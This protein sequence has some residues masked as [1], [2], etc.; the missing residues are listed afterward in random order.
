[1]EDRY[2]LEVEDGDLIA[3]DNESQKHYFINEHII[4]LLNQQSKRIKELE[5]RA[6]TLKRSKAHFKKVAETV[7][8]LLIKLNKFIGNPQTRDLNYY[9]V[10]EDTKNYI[11]ELKQSQKQLAINELEK[12][13]EGMIWNDKPVKIELENIDTTP[14]D[15]AKMFKQ[16]E[17]KSLDNESNPYPFCGSTEFGK[18]AINK[19]DNATE[20]Q[21]LDDLND[22]TEDLSWQ[23][24]LDD[25]DKLIS[26]AQDIENIAKRL[27]EL[28]ET[29]ETK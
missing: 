14:T 23:Y 16:C 18:V 28:K 6:N 21:C 29:N 1:M 25:L 24:Q 5:G 17:V 26:K 15:F 2:T 12:V 19:Y 13:K 4:D 11:E 9:K 8:E 10:I 27:K 7:V 20:Q 3:F 22:L